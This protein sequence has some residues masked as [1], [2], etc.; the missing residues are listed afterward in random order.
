[1][2]HNGFYQKMKM[3]QKNIITSDFPVNVLLNA[4]RSAKG[5][6]NRNAEK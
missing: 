6:L 3:T 5:K 1:M 2:K 4:T